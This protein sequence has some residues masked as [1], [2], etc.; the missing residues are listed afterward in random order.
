MKVVLVAALISAAHPVLEQAEIA[1]DRVR[2]DL[3]AN[4]LA[5]RV[6]H[7]VGALNALDLLIVDG[8]IIRHDAGLFGDVSVDNWQDRRGFDVRDIDA[9]N[10]AVSFHE[11]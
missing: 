6:V 1:L 11:A 9:A 7:G 5:A 4:M 3:S 8:R 10:L 2:V